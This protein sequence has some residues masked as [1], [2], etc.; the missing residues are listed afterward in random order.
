MQGEGTLKSVPF[1]VRRP[2]GTAFAYVLLLKT[3][4][5]IVFVG[6]VAMAMIGSWFVQLISNS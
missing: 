3:L 6:L 2:N 4:I 5:M 1:F